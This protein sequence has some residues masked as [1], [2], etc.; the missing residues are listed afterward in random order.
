MAHKSLTL[1]TELAAAWHVKRRSNLNVSEGQSRVLDL[2]FEGGL[3][4]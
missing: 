1:Q 2:G 4:Q 3:M